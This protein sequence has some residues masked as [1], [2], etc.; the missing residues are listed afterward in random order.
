[1]SEEWYAKSGEGLLEL[2][3]NLRKETGSL[4]IDVLHEPK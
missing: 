3:D 4:T 2:L 1:M